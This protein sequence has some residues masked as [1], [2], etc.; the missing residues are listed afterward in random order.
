MLN[1]WTYTHKSS[2]HSIPHNLHIW[3][4]SIINQ[5]IG[6]SVNQST[7]TI[8]W[9][10][11][12][13]FWDTIWNFLFRWERCWKQALIF[14]CTTFMLHYMNFTIALLSYN[15]L[16]WQHEKSHDSGC[17]LVLSDQS[18]CLVSGSQVLPLCTTAEE[19]GLHSHQFHCLTSWMT[20]S[21]T[22]LY[23]RN[24]NITI[25]FVPIHQKFLISISI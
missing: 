18:V 19:S 8:K 10:T 5:S 4:S 23:K 22:Q 7:N 11:S 14:S 6:Q 9:S 17:K 25:N 20:W 15:L 1:V 2:Y 21:R 13:N 16:Y 24:A 12:L 3:N